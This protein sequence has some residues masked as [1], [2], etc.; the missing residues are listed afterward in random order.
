MAHRIILIVSFLSLALL[1][2]AQGTDSHVRG[3]VS[4]RQTGE[5][6]PGVSVLY[7]KSQGTIADDKGFY[8]FTT[9]SGNQAITF[10][11]LGYKTLTRNISL[12]PGE[13]LIVNVLLEQDVI[14]M[15]QVVVTASRIEQRMAELTVSMSIIKPGSIASQHISSPMELIDKAP[16]LEVLD[17]QASMRGGSGFSYGVG[18]RVLMLVDGLPIIAPDAGNIRWQFLPLDNISQIEIIKG[19]SSVVYGSSALNGVINFRTADATVDPIT[20]AYVEAGIYDKPRN[21]DWIWWNSPTIFTNV[22]FNH[23]QKFGSTDFGIGGTILL[24]PGYRL[25]NED[26][27]GRIHLKVK[28]FNKK[29]DG[30]IYGVAVH[31]GQVRKTDF[32]LW[33]NATTGAL[34]HDTSTAIALKGSFLAIDPFV[35]YKKPGVFSHDLRARYQRSVNLFPESAQNDSEAN[36]FYAEYQFWYFFSK[37]LHINTGISQNSSKVLSNFYG[38]HQSINLAAF[39]QAEVSPSE[40]LKLVAGMR[41]E[42]NSLDNEPDKLVPLFRAG[43]NYKLADY[44]FLR[45]SYGQGYRFPSIAEHFA[46]TTLGAVQV[47]PNPNILAESGW[48]AEVGIRQGLK[49]AYFSGQA[50]LALFYLQNKD[51]IEFLFGIYT[52]PITGS[53]GF[54]FRAGN[55]EASRVYGLELEYMLTNQLGEFRNTLTGS[56]VYMFPVEYNP[57]TG[58]NTDDML[59]YR[60]HHA[61]KVL[62]SS[63]YRKFEAGFGLIARSKMLRI[64]DVFLD[65]LTRERILPGFYDYWQTANTGHF[66]VDLQAGYQL[67]EQ[68]KLSLAIKNLTNVEYIGRPGDIQ[69]QRTFSLRLSGSF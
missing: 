23:L 3:F 22:G 4:D 12:K 62:F 69:P 26:N 58:E 33:E 14:Q 9:V 47:Y 28:H 56:Y 53:T 24:N 63:S 7:G 6:I 19:A 2:H 37:W 29:I 46:S 11:M 65:P 32:V 60:R 42:H 21:R 52:N 41:V 16:G 51:M 1:L 17:G 20:K 10:R 50:D 35:S 27:G 40:R 34:I 13:T 66:I 67:S 31:N 38:D 39:M 54:G 57:G 25:R 45:A 5:T 8:T 36:N 30:L 49:T 55:V 44:T 64:D 48:N 61:A 68:L 18:S 15:D 59:K 43:L